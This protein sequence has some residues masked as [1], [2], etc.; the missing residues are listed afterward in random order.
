M[1]SSSTNAVDSVSS[2]DDPGEQRSDK[3]ESESTWKHQVLVAV[4]L[5]TLF[6]GSYFGYRHF[7]SRAPLR[8]SAGPAPVT[9]TTA[10]AA[11]E[12]WAVELTAVGTL[13]AFQGVEV[14]SEL[15]GIVTKIAFKSGD[16]IAADKILVQLDSS[17][18]EAQLRSLKSQ[19]EQAKSDLE[20]AEEL[21][22]KNAIAQ[23]EYDQLATD[24]ENL[25]AQAAAQ[26]ATI[27]KKRIVAPF[28]GR[29]GIRK[30]DLGAYVSPGTP[31][32]TL[33]QVDPV[34]VNFDLPEQHSSTVKADLTVEIQVSAFP[35]RTF[36]GKV[37]AISPLVAEATR[38]FG[39]QAT[40][41]NEDVLLR[42][43]MF[44]DVTLRL[45]GDREVVAIPETAVTF[46]AYGESVFLVHESTEVTSTVDQQKAETPSSQA[47]VQSSS[48][49]EATERRPVARQVMVKTGKRRG[50]KIE[51]TQG[52]QSG[53]R[54]VTAG[55]LKLSDGSLLRV[56]DE[57]VGRDVPARSTKP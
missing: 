51:V 16:A 49:D 48:S 10:I 34:Y 20:R 53:D 43:G 42:P 7:A 25:K 2:D 50:L 5:T 27:D 4:A 35:D 39:V 41:R 6:C 44:A 22:R 55:Q 17:A 36:T 18:E 54:V 8:Q 57:D 3:P 38:S 33:Q 56:S 21:K 9:V 47:A 46:N 26:Q 12:T 45:P 23:N 14:T 29:L 19:L 40:I 52:I 1:S 24:M 28:G 15:A 37:T 32:V 31:V 13:E 11:S 30:T